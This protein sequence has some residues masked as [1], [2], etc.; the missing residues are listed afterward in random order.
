M[1]LF[2]IL[3]NMYGADLGL[4]LWNSL[5]SQTKRNGSSINN[6]ISTA[7]QFVLSL[8]LKIWHFIYCNKKYS[9]YKMKTTNMETQICFNKSPE[10]SPVYQ[11]KLPCSYTFPARCFKTNLEKYGPC[12]SKYE[13]V[14]RTRSQINEHMSDTGDGIYLIM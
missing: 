4:H 14:K 2:H 8:I 6:K 9:L 10:F 1:I 13:F 11:G 3:R 7:Q 12:I 5:Q